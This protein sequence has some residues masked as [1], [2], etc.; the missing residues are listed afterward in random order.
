VPR[1]CGSEPSIHLSLEADETDV[2]FTGPSSLIQSR[3][4]R[5][6]LVNVADQL[7]SCRAIEQN[8]F[9]PPA[10]RPKLASFIQPDSRLK[11]L[12]LPQAI[13]LA[14]KYY[15]LKLM[16]FADVRLH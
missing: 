10:I 6:V 4:G 15:C 3:V 13:H 11:H 8:G 2:L 12:S 1:H 5:V 14:A 16:E 7:P 9:V